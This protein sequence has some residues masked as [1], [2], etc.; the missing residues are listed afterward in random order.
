MI[1]TCAWCGMLI[2]VRQP[3]TDIRVSHSICKCCSERLCQELPPD[4]GNAATDT[5]ADDGR[6]GGSGLMR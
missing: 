5:E 1:V 4:E 3:L 2:D 6:A